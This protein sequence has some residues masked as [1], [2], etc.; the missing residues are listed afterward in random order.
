MIDE[1]T[2]NCGSCSVISREEW[3]ILGSR[4]KSQEI[5]Q[6]SVKLRWLFHDKGV[7]NSPN[8]YQL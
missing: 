4:L 5:F 8:S 6:Y 7:A 1:A 3:P 2:L